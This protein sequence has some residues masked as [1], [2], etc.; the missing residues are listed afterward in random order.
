[1][2]TPLDTL[3]TVLVEEFLASFA[4]LLDAAPE[5][6]PGAVPA[7]R[8]WTATLAV[9]GGLDGRLVLL[10][11]EPGAEGLAGPALG[12]DQ[13]PTEAAIGSTLTDLLQ[14]A[15]ATSMERPDVAGTTLSLE[16]LELTE[17]PSVEALQG[18]AVSIAGLTAPL[19]LAVGGGVATRDASDTSATAGTGAPADASAAGAGATGA[20][21]S[22]APAP[23]RAAPG[24]T[25]ATSIS[26]G[27]IDLNS[28]IGVILDI[29]LPVVVRFGQ[30]DLPV[31]TLARLGPG[32][33]IDLGRSP[34]DPVELLVSNRVVAHGE[35]V[36]VG[37]NYG[38]RILD[39]VSPSERMPSMEA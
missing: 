1:M 4:P 16:G 18:W 10:L 5:A 6:G 26:G 30:T 36:I 37:G 19:A 8:V 15:A 22:P 24:R 27:P 31:R 13:T 14:Q 33:V 17:A 34:D 21:D 38:I 7:G 23:P 35:V 32:S 39:V 20:A 29:D 28:R 9:T 3:R 11:D 2:S 25:P 12:G